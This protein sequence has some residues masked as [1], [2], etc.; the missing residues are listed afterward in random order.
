MLRGIEMVLEDFDNN[1]YVKT[2][3]DENIRDSVYQILI[4]LKCHENPNIKTIGIKIN[5]CDY[6]LANSGATTDPIVLDAL[7]DNLRKFYPTATIYLIENDASGTNADNLYR[8]LKFN[9]LE[10]KYSCEFITE[11]EFKDLE[12][13]NIH[14]PFVDNNHCFLSFLFVHDQPLYA[15]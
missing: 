9:E 7:L 1:V 8:F 13:T 3:K 4:A 6:R 14:V 15:V 12:K 2:I 11:I 5:L 10:E